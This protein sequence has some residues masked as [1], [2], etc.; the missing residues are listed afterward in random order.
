MATIFTVNYSG[1]YGGKYEF[2]ADASESNVSSSNNSS[3]VS[4]SIYLRRKDSSSNGA[5]N[6]YGTG[7][8]ITIDGT[9]Y[10]GTSTWDTRNTTAWQYLG[11]ASKTVTHN[12]DG[13]K[14][15]SI[16]ASHTGNSSSSSSKMGNASGSG[17]FTLENIPRHTQIYASVSSVGLNSIGVEWTTDD[18]IS[19]IQYRLNSGSWV[20]VETDMN[21]NNGQ[22]TISGLDPN[23]TY[24]ID[25]DAKRRDSGLWSFAAGKGASFSRTTKDIARISSY[26][27]STNLGDSY[28][29]KYTNPS[30][31]K[32][33]VGIYDV[34]GR[35]YYAE[36]RTVTGSSYTFNF[37]DTELDSMYA[38]MGTSNSLSA[39]LYINTAD[40]TYRES[41]D[42]TIK[43]TGNI[44]TIWEKISSV[45]KRGK[46][47][48]KV[49][50]VWKRA[51]MWKNVS[52][53]W[54]RAK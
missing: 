27:S 8:T 7:W 34:D 49:N 30:G 21:A 6:N 52:G 51:I 10:S 36:Y 48:L 17:N 23:T 2:K 16:S 26:N 45:W 28:A 33:Q 47:W 19:V 31:A 20:D 40:N 37:T 53:K 50:G 1:G 4:V 9:T 24:N 22:F 15:V 13:S 39:K 25:L 38:A 43:L 12:S 42:I 32:V 11:S 46:L 29:I 3:L 5:Y 14:T 41:K 18:N 54:K 35:N 44:K